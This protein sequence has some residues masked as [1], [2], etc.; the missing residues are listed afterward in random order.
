MTKG[1]RRKE[2]VDNNFVIISAKCQQTKRPYLIK[3]RKDIQH[4]N[5][6]GIDIDT[7]SYK[8]IGA[9]Q[10]DK[11]YYELSDKDSETNF[12]INTEELRGVP[13][14]PCC[15]NQ[16]SFAVCTCGAVHCVG[17]EKLSTCPW[18]LNQAVYGYGEGGMDI[19]RTQG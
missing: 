1:P 8:L 4:Q 12:K 2:Y 17:N 10:V 9:F 18:C 13:T 7:L 3:Y 15:G 19:N 14:C 16:I 11:M 6:G 5:L